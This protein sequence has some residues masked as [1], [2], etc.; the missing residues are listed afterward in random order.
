MNK[1]E[2][3]E[4]YKGLKL[5]DQCEDF[6]E[7]LQVAIVRAGGC[8]INRTQL[9]NMTIKEISDTLLNNNSIAAVWTEEDTL[10]K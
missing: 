4:H 9:E 7:S 8:F 3:L 6:V 1:E 2:F 5:G 10:T